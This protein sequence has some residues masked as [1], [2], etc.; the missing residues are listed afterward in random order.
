MHSPDSHQC[1]VLE[2]AQELLDGA[3][4]LLAD[5]KLIYS[6]SHS[7]SWLSSHSLTPSIS[8]SFGPSPGVIASCYLPQPACKFTQDKV[9]QHLHKINSKLTADQIVFHELNAIIEYTQ[10]GDTPF[11]AVAHVFHI[12]PNH[13]KHPKDSFQYSLGDNHGGLK[14]VRC[15]LLR[16]DSGKEVPCDQLMTSC[17]YFSL[18]LISHSM[19]VHNARPRSQGLLHLWWG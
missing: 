1:A 18:S 12:D 14:N 13:F 11:Q 4:F 15:S 19:H 7:S 3:R 8:S 16:D 2:Q 17:M 6:S 5:L 9:R 10:T